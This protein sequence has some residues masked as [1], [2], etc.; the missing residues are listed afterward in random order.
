MYDLQDTNLSYFS[1]LDFILYTARLKHF[2][3]AA[4]LTNMKFSGLLALASLAIATP[5]ELVER[6][7]GCPASTRLAGAE[8]VVQAYGA[9]VPGQ[10]YQIFDSIPFGVPNLAGACTTVMSVFITD[11][12]IAIL[13]TNA[14]SQ[15]A[16]A[17]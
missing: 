7:S 4:Q 8:K 15:M 13:T 11:I 1:V 10:T 17:A 5:V 3:R 14:A 2:L 6:A 9:T 12:S 16:A